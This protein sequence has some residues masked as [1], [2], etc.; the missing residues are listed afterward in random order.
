[1]GERKLLRESVPEESGGVPREQGGR[2]LSHCNP[3]EDVPF[4]HCLR[5]GNFLGGVVKFRKP[6]PDGFPF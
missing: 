5:K 6:P 1:M 2:L 3:R 4:A